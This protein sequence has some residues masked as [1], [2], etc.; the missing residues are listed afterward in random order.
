VSAG[1][2]TLPI[3]VKTRLTVSDNVSL[4]ILEAATVA[5]AESSRIGQ[6]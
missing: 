4:E 2:I 3:G 1:N 6:D 5:R